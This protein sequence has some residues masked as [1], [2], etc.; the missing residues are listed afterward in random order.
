MMAER[1]VTEREK[2]E[3]LLVVWHRAQEGTH[4]QQ[5]AL[6]V[7][8]LMFLTLVRKGRIVQLK[9]EFKTMK[10]TFRFFTNIKSEIVC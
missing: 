8:Q 6:L 10:A 7:V 3:L 5:V 2:R 1:G 9:K 4:R